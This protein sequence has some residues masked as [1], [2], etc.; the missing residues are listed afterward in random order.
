VLAGLGGGAPASAQAPARAPA[1]AASYPWLPPGAPA[2]EPLAARFPPPPGFTRRALP[3][4]SYGAWLRSLPL[5][6]PGSPV[7]LFDGRRKPNQGAHLAV[8][9]LDV[10]ARDLQQCADAVMRL[11]AEHAWASG[12][13]G[14][15]C[16]PATSGQAMPW[17]RWARGERPRVR[18]AALHWEPAG[19]PGG[20]GGADHASFRRY[21]DA[22]F[23]FAGTASLERFQAQRLPAASVQ[24]GD[25]YLQGGAPGHAVLVVD[26]AEDASGRRVVMLAQSYMPAQQVHV[27]DNPARPGSPWF[28]VPA[29]GEPLHT[30]EW[31]FPPGSLRRLLPAARPC[32]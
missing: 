20:A 32:R 13:A 19:A 7:L 14:D 28:E 25:L 30:P 9:A 4:G 11:W 16:F 15:V 31:V 3:P 5:L 10:G 12:R 2:H 6:P 22:V 29:D 23:T 26:A 18:G 17:A 27:L 1:P 21:L 24:P 8:V